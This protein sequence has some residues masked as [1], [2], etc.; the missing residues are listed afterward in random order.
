MDIRPA[1]RADALAIATVHVRSWQAAYPGLIP[2]SYLDA[3]DPLLRR[4]QWLAVLDA[5]DWPSTGTFVLTGAP[6]P[7]APE[8]GAPEP[9][10]P[11]PGATPVMGF[12]SFSPTRDEDDDPSLVGELQTLYLD[13]LAWRQGGGSMLLGAV[14]SQLAEAGFRSASAWVLG[15]NERARH[16]YESHHW[17]HD[18]TSK[19]H[20]WGAFVATDLRYRLSDLTADV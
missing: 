8:P 17:R 4:P 11:E 2:Q 13:P 7:S 14:R 6:E 12:A 16:F 1:T 10:A 5:T 15:T 9:G 18:G 3:L 20:D 19:L